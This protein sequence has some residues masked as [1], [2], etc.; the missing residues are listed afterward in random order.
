MSFSISLHD[1]FGRRNDTCEARANR[2]AAVMPSRGAAMLRLCQGQQASA[3]P[4]TSTA[5]S[6]Q[7]INS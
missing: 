7:R 1:L 5:D 6:V 2:S 3:V 4:T